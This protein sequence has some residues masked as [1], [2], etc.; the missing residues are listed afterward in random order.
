M[1]LFEEDRQLL[2]SFLWIDNDFRFHKFHG[3]NTSVFIQ[4]NDAIEWMI[5]KGWL[6]EYTVDRKRN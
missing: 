4:L 3:Y 2:S 1:C 5:N 6:V